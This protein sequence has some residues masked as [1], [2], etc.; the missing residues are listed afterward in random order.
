M[1]RAGYA[2]DCDNDDDWQLRLGRW[3]GRVASATRGKRGQRFLKLAL[4]ALDQMQDKRLARGTFGVGD[5]GCMCLMSSLATETGKASVLSEVLRASA[6]DEWGTRDD[7]VHANLLVA[8]AFDIASP[9]AQELVYLNDNGPW[10]E[11]PSERWKRI[12]RTIAEM[13]QP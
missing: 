1:D 2:T 10:G 9:L 8:E 6:L 5:D 12:R 3:R 4:K 7:P 13:I 11:T